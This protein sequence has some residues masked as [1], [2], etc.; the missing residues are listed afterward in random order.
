MHPDVARSISFWGPCKFT[1][2]RNLLIQRKIQFHPRFTRAALTST[3]QACHGRPRERE[4]RGR[5]FAEIGLDI[6][7]LE[8]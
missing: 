3:R 5:L 2:N 8:S 6:E 1:Y 4:W 7:L